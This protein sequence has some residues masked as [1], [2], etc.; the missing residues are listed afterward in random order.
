MRIKKIGHCCLVLEI[1]GLKIMTDPG[2]FT[3]QSHVQET[4]ID[5]VLIT[6]EHGDHL[7]IES[8][9]ELLEKNP[10]A[11]VITN[12]SVAKLLHEQGIESTHIGGGES[13]EVKGVKIEGFGHDHA[14]IYESFGQVENTGYLVAEKFYFPGDSFFNPKKAVDVLALPIAGPWMRVGHAVDFLRAVKPRVAFGVHD[15]ILVP[16]FRGFAIALFEKFAPDTAYYSIADGS[17]KEF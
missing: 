4:G 16:G 8:L 17:M 12:A 14:I 3:T 9:K 5:V 2:M 1:D 11:H 15:G 7:H 6:H 10:D 13:A